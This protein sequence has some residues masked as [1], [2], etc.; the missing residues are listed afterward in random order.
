MATTY[1]IARAAGVSRVCVSQVL[2]NAPGARVSEDTRRRVL[3]LARQMNYVPPAARRRQSRANAIAYLLCTDAPTSKARELIIR[4]PG[5]LRMATDLQALAAPDD[6]T[7]QFL[8]VSE[9]RPTLEQTERLLEVNRPLGAVLDGLV[10]HA[11]VRLMQSLALPFVV[12]G[13]TSFAFTE[14]DTE[15]MVPTVSSDPRQQ[16]RRM[17]EWFAGHGCHR[18][19]LATGHDRFLVTRI[20][21]QAYRQSISDLGMQT[22]PAL[23]QVSEMERGVAVYER[24]AELGIEYDGIVFANSTMAANAMPLIEHRE[25]D[26]L[27]GATGFVGQEANFALAGPVTQEYNQAIYQSLCDQIQ[28]RR[29]RRTHVFLP[30]VFQEPRHPGP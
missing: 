27:V 7:T 1:D 24:Y 12:V 19:A 17:L 9:D 16:M 8:V 2:N 14:T 30:V 15:R 6:R 23:I 11:H 5:H 13:V 25:P 4:S 22:D 26:R 3:E 29:R 21:I 28:D 20:L 18:V 10:T